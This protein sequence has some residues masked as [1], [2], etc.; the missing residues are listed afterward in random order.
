[1]GEYPCYFHS[2][3]PL[4]DTNVKYTNE[5]P[6]VACPFVGLVHS[7]AICLFLFGAHQQTSRRRPGRNRSTLAHEHMKPRLVQSNVARFPGIFCL[8]HTAT[9]PVRATVWIAISG[10]LISACMRHEQ[11]IGQMHLITH[12]Q[13][14]ET[15]LV[16]Y[17]SQLPSYDQRQAVAVSH[18]FR[19]FVLLANI[20]TQSCHKYFKVL[21]MKKPVLF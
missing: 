14:H 17:G 16:S 21:H 19:F 6:R 1:M 20:A 15:G 9:C 3:S 5:E 12:S 11:K 10:C 8:D 18:C 4:P 13:I 2:P 7:S